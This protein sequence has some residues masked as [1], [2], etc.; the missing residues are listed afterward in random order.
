MITAFVP[1]KTE[2]KNPLAEYPCADYLHNALRLLEEKSYK[3]AYTE[4]CYAIAKSGGELTQ[5]EKNIFSR[6]VRGLATIG[7]DLKKPLIDAYPWAE[8]P[9]CSGSVNMENIREYIVNGCVTY[10]CHCGQALDWSV[11]DA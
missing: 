4:I 9:S 8:C 3:N 6:L 5:H 2:K 10:C 11:D 1:R 7:G